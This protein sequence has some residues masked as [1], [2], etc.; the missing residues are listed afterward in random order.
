MTETQWQYEMWNVN[1]MEYKYGEYIFHLWKSVSNLMFS[2][3]QIVEVHVVRT[4][5]CKGQN[6]LQEHNKNV[7][8]A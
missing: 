7:W 2:V 1:C 4:C 8:F 3:F 5:H 6:V